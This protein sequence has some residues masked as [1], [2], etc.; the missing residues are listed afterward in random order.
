M[1]NPTRA[2]SRDSLI[3]QA[4]TGISDDEVI[5]VLVMDRRWQLVLDCLDC[6]KPPFSKG[7]LVN[8]RQLLIN[9]GL[10]Q[11]LIERTVEIAKEKGGF[12]S[13]KL[14]AALDSSPLWGAGKVEDTYNLRLSYPQESSEADGISSRVFSRKCRKCY[15]STNGVRFFAQSRT[16]L[17]LGRPRAALSSLGNTPQYL[18]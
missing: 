11:R 18:Q 2:T 1:S 16:G 15:R 17:R 6:Q 12:H 9:K 3:L 4:Y 7:T 14:R 5:E 8:F 10:D 13:V